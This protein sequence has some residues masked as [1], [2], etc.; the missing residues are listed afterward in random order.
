MQLIKKIPISKPTRSDRFSVPATPLKSVMVSKATQ[1]LAI[2]LPISAGIKNNLLSIQ[3]IIFIY[4][5]HEPP[6]NK[7]KLKM[8]AMKE[9]CWFDIDIFIHVDKPN[10]GQ[11]V[12]IPQTK[13]YTIER[14]QSN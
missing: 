14:K 2:N 6:L 11:R 9:T 4:Y 1:Y 5:S 3:S 10:G 12:E 7:R 8:K 13:F